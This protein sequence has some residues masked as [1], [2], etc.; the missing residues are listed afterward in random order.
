MDGFAVPQPQQPTGNPL[1]DNP[2]LKAQVV[3]SMQQRQQSPIQAAVMPSGAAPPPVAPVSLPDAKPAMPPAEKKPMVF[4]PFGQSAT[5]MAQRGTEEG[6]Q[7]ER[8]RLEGSGSGIS[9]I[10]KRI[11]S[12]GFGQ[13]HPILGKIAGIGAQGLATLGDI[14]L[15]LTGAGRAIEPLIPGTEGHHQ[16]DLRRANNAL[17]G[18]LT[19][20]GKQ[21][22]I[23]G[24][25]AKTQETQA[26]TENL[27]NPPDKF[28][29]LS[30]AQGI[31]S[32]DPKTGTT[33]P[34]NDASGKPLQPYNP[35]KEHTIDE[36]AY[37]SL[38]GQGRSP[39]EALD[40]IYG[41]KNT[42]VEDLP[43]L[44]L[45][46]LQ[47]G[48]QAKAALIKKAHEDTQVK[49]TQPPGVTM[50]VPDANGQER[51]QRLTA[52]QVVAPGAQTAAGVN[53]LN[54][55][56]TLQRNAGGRADLVLS[57]I[58]DVLSDLRQNASQLGPGMGRFNDIYSGKIGA[59]NAE[60]S[61]L[62]ADLHL[63]G[64]AVALAH[65]QGRMSN[66]LLTEF[67]SMIAS[68]QQ[69][70]ENIEAVLSKV[71]NFMQRASQQGKRPDNSPPGSGKQN[72]PLGIR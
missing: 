50:I 21:A 1:L 23:A 62:M 31:Q 56:T 38:V 30:T 69:S 72:D 46:A 20:E 8:E 58:P 3:A 14:G 28:S 60:F 26:T 29:P 64:T 27:R 35:A 68:P 51:V 34:L 39:V 55:P 47:S 67:N 59:P 15:N 54:T 16:L 41:A 48:D 32:F 36:Q 2:A 52:G 43:H 33:T 4:G 49:P 65:A 9:Q 45:D 40:T 5:P 53:S 12:S 22:G 61:G 25:Q 44:Y 13:N 18:D 71:Q 19:N 6:D 11:E 70:P 42:K 17:T 57:A 63:L 66:E 37:D 7:Q 10:A 24:E